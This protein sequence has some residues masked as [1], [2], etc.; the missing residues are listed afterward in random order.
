MVDVISS[1]DSSTDID[2][3]AFYSEQAGRT[4]YT[5]EVQLGPDDH[6]WKHLGNNEWVMI[7]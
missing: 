7:D 1:D 5:G 4:I 3:G 2:D 6:Y